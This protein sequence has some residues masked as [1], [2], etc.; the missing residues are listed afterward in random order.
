MF[1]ILKKIWSAA[2]TVVLA[3]LMVFVVL[4]VRLRLFGL[5]GFTVLSGSMEPAYQTGSVIYVKAIDVNELE[6]GDVI[7]FR[8]SGGTVVTHRIEEVL[9]ENGARRYRTKG[10]A[11]EI[12][13]G[14]PVSAGNV[15]GTPV[16]S[17]PYLGYALTYIQSPPGLYVGIAVGAWLLLFILLPSLIFVKGEKQKVISKEEDE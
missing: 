12:A 1:P 15:I 2:A 11:N 17:V 14:T 13:D 3:V 9:E 10:D 4:L 8:I 6:V 7:T 16:F 5:Q